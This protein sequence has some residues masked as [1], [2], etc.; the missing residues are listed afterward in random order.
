MEM[1]NPTSNASER[2]HK[3]R[4]PPTQLL[5]SEDARLQTDSFLAER[6]IAG[7][8]DPGREVDQT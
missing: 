4:E 1:A 3:I 7:E 6:M 8:P 2:P 5:R